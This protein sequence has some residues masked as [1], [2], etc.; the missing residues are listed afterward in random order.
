ELERGLALAKTMID[1]GAAAG[2][3]VVALLTAMDRPLGHAVGNALETEEAILTLQGGGP[4]DLRE[5]TVVQTAEMML[6]AG[7]ETDR[8]AAIAT[9]ERALDDGRAL[10]KMREIVVAQ[11]GNGA[12]LDDPAILPQAA[13]S[14]TLE[15]DREGVL[16]AM[17]V[18]AIGRAAVALGAGR[19]AVDD[20]IDPGVGFHITAKP[21]LAVRR[22]EPL[23]TVYASNDADARA[24]LGALRAAMPIVDQLTD[25]PLPLVSHRVTVDGVEPLE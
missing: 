23:A 21:G 24:A 9:C 17:D 8:A 14:A 5:L 1:V 19:A 10:E 18:K 15:A 13:T 3:R 4:S 6:L 11:G 20:R 22:G 12:V 7:V 25:A 16:G 2:C